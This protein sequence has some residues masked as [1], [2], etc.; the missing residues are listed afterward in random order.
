M[1]QHSCAARRKKLD[2]PRHARAKLAGVTPSIRVRREIIDA[3]LLHARAQP[4]LE[5]CGLLAGRDSLITNFYPAQN[6][7]PTPATSYEIAQ[8]DLF[9]ILREIRKNNQELLA[10]CHSHPTTENTPSP[11]DIATAYYPA[12]A[13]IIV[14]PRPEARN[15]IRAFQIRKAQVTERPIATA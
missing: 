5:S 1:F 7:S 12:A 4:A 8:P 6:V 2:R 14:D 11:T 15:P 10:I 9:R 13:Y 3:L